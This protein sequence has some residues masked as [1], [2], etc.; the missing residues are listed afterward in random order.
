MT[1]QIE[2]PPTARRP[3][4]PA[5]LA[6]TVALAVL[7]WRA[8]AL[9]TIPMAMTHYG[10]QVMGHLSR[11]VAG[12]GLVFVLAYGALFTTP[13]LS[14]SRRV[15]A[16]R[17]WNVFFIVSLFAYFTALAAYVL[18]KVVVPVTI[19]GAWRGWP[20]AAIIAIWLA[21]WLPIAAL[22]AAV[23]ELWEPSEDMAKRLVLALVVLLHSAMLGMA[24]TA[25]WGYG[26]GVHH[27]S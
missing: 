1:A 3:S 26:A 23:L 20:D 17:P 9:P 27:M 10:E 22:A 5:V 6:I 15:E 13:W 21:A 25:T 24:S 16:N 11:V 4:L 2:S 18:A 8:P 12:M 14:T 19:D 7:A